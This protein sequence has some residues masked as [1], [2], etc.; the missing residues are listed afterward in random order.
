M[1]PVRFSSLMM[2]D[3]QTSLYMVVNTVNG[4]QSLVSHS[5]HKTCPQSYISA[6]NQLDMQTQNWQ[7]ICNWQTYSGGNIFIYYIYIYIYIYIYT[8]FL[9][10]Y[11]YSICLTNYLSH[12]VSVM[13]I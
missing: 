8:I 12:T 5:C 2:S 13:E 6:G 3:T 11:I 4:W 9:Y 7:V 10:I 1:M